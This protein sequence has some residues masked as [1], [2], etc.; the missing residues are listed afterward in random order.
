MLDEG[1][2][3]GDASAIHPVAV[4]SPQQVD[5]PDWVVVISCQNWRYIIKVITKGSPNR[6]FV[7][8]GKIESDLELV[9]GRT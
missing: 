4:K 5:Q 7:L 3:A 2:G 8:L 1:I 9:L 6:Q